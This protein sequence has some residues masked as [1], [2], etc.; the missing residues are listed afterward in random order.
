MDLT[1]GA[2]GAAA[3]GAGD[4]AGSEGGAGGASAAPLRP[5]EQEPLLAAR[6]MV[7]DCHDKLLDVD[8][9]DRCA[10]TRVALAVLRGVKHA[11]SVAHVAPGHFLHSLALSPP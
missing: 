3:A 10:P 5:L 2:G 9:I 11:R 6:I 4:A 8:D 7:E 1:A